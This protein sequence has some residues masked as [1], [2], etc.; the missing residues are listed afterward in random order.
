[1]WNEEIV[2]LVAGYTE[3]VINGMAYIALVGVV[4]EAQRRGIASKLVK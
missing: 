4:E 2:G 1:M 3:N